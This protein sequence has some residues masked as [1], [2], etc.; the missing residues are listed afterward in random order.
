MPAVELTKEDIELLLLFIQ[1]AGSDQDWSTNA[2][3]SERLERLRQKL[4]DAWESSGLIV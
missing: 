2:P 3:L 4:R 1:A